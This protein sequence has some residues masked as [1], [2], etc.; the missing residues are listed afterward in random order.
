MK[1][2]ILSLLTSLMLSV[3]CAGICPHGDP[4]IDLLT[5]PGGVDPRDLAEMHAQAESLCGREIDLYLF[6]EFLMTEDGDI[7]DLDSVCTLGAE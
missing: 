7:S 5:S 3:G 4:L 1:L 2:I 6:V